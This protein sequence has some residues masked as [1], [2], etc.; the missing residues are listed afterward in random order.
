[1]KKLVALFL[2]LA[3]CMSLCV[4][5]SAC[6]K[7][8]TDDG[9]DL[10]AALEYVKTLYKNST[11]KTTRD[12]TRVGTVRVNDKTYDVV[13][14]VNVGEE[15]VKV[16]KG[17]DGTVTIDVN[18][19][20]TEDVSYTLTATITSGDKVVSYSWKHV[21]PKAAP[22]FGPIVDEAYALE[23]G[24]SMD[25]EVTLTG[26]ISGIPTP[27]DDGYK[28]IT[29]TMNVIGVEGKPIEC[30]RLKGDGA[31]SLKVGDTITVVG[32]LTNYNGKI[33]FAAGCV[34]ESV[35]PGF[36][37]LHEFVRRSVCLC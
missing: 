5:L 20:A 11:E 25:R 4:G 22:D 10:D 6:V 35:V 3:L 7:K 27:Y 1:M 19:E 32:T 8:D 14:S 37:T 12:Y 15:H 2:V 26:I 28:N 13:W 23:A 36:G 31:E 34:L 24:A 30:Y 9:A 33:Q 29:V 18:E 16:V 21:L 17:T